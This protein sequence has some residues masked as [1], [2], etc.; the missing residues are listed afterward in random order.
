MCD[1][2]SYICDSGV[3]DFQATGM[4]GSNEKYLEF[5]IYTEKIGEEDNAEY[6][7][8]IPHLYDKVSLKSENKTSYAVLDDVK[9]SIFNRR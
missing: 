3:G 6:Y 2:E 5:Q 8:K 4:D 9:T 1:G 7:F